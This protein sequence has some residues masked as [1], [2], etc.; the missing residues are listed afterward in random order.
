MIGGGRE[1]IKVGREVI[2]EGI[3]IAFHN[4]FFKGFKSDGIMFFSK[5]CVNDGNWGK[6]K[7]RKTHRL[8]GGLIWERGGSSEMGNPKIG[9]GG[10]EM[11]RM[12]VKG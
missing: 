6:R 11:R 9:G 5:F 8:D 4:K 2:K 12:Q 3:V 7:S 1:V 10:V